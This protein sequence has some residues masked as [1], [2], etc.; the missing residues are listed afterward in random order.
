VDFYFSREVDIL[1]SIVHPNIVKFY[2]I[3]KDDTDLYIIT[4]FIDVMKIVY[5]T[6]FKLKT[7]Q[8]K[9]GPNLRDALK[10][11]LGWEE[12]IN[13]AIQI[14][15][16]ISYLHQHKIIHRDVK[17]ENVLIEK[18]TLNVKLC[19]FGFSRL[20]FIIFIYFIYFILFRFISTKYLIL[21]FPFFFFL[22]L[23]QMMSKLQNIKHLSEVNGLKHLKLCF[24][25]IMMNA[26]ISF[27]MVWYY[28]S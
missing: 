28:V 27:L 1:S 3:S 2:G 9:K 17:T 12:R 4:E 22:V 21:F 8:N 5:F 18:D 23:H 19:D 7:N 20:Y 11:N 15:Q 10:E 16:S 25:W 13:I 6:M 24:V 14:A 26:L